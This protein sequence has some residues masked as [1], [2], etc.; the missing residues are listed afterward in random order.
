M[1][2]IAEFFGWKFS[3]SDSK[4][5][6]I[7]SNSERPKS[8]LETISIQSIFESFLGNQ[9]INSFELND[10]IYTIDTHA[11]FNS[12]LYDFE[13]N[14]IFKI[15][16]INDISEKH[17]QIHQSFKLKEDRIEFFSKIKDHI[18]NSFNN[19]SSFNHLL[20][21]NLSLNNNML[22]LDYLYKYDTHIV[23]GETSKFEKIGTI[24]NCISDLIY[25]FEDILNSKVN[26][27]IIVA[28]S[29]FDTIQRLNQIESN[30]DEICDFLLEIRDISNSSN[31][32]KDSRQVIFYV[33]GI[34]P[35]PQEVK[36]TIPYGR[37]FGSTKTKHIGTSNI[38]L[39]KNFLNL[40]NLCSEFLYRMESTF[41][42]I[43]VDILLDK[44]KVT[45]N[46][47]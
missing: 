22:N 14:S 5:Q 7:E 17:F 4:L 29:E 47:N 41:D 25:R 21:V 34:E 42:D 8:E 16:I 1:R 3:K 45:F 15:D 46:F 30:W 13:P 2:K 31:Y 32:I 43:T 37:N 38:R 9:L 28:R 26:Y 33:D 40:M 20:S 11:Q 6:T 23:I 27:Q 39:T 36:Y 44:N 18:R 35:L 19:Y 24:S 12:D 10:G